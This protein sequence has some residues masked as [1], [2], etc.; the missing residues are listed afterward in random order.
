MFK[1]LWSK[2]KSI[3]YDWL[4]LSG[5]VMILYMIQ[6]GFAALSKTGVDGLDLS[7]GL[8]IYFYVVAIA[9]LVFGFLADRIKPWLLMYLMGLCG[10]IGLLG[11]SD[12]W[13]F[14]LGCGMAGAA[15]KILPFSIPLKNKDS[16]VEALRI[17]PQ[18]SAKNIGA[19]LFSALLGG[20]IGAAIS[21]VE[22]VFIM[23]GAFAGLTLWAFY[24]T[25]NHRMKLMKWNVGETLSL[26]KD[27]K[28]WVFTAWYTVAGVFLYYIMR[29]IIPGFMSLGMTKAQAASL[30][31]SISI[32]ACVLRWGAAWLGD[33]IGYFKT[34]LIGT[35]GWVIT[36]FTLPVNPI[37]GTIL[38]FASFSISTPNQW[39]C[40][41]KWFGDKLGTAMGMVFVVAYIA[42][43]F[44][45]GQWTK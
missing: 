24:T 27:W 4:P 43:G 32:A 41:K 7:A 25:R 20:A 1:K 34:M 31:G 16:K 44:M 29:S 26:L 28:W 5:I 13:V 36:F 6:R 14:G 35:V 38:Y 45:F 23:A 11:V 18:A 30:F 10:T 22:F 40:G 8:S 42:M 15:V 17:A 19:G 21:A 9:A 2:V 12:P 3:S 37:I 39:A 33:R